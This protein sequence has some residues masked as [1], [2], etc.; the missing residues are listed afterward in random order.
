MGIKTREV[1]GQAFYRSVPVMAGYI[2]LGIGF[3]ILLR[4]AGFGVIWA[5]A[6][7]ALIYA[8]S[9]QYV[10][11]GLLT[12]GASVVTTIITTIMVNARHLFYSISMIDKYKG[13]GKFKPYMIFALTDETYSLLC[14]DRGP[15]AETLNLYRFFVSLFNQCYWVTG[16]VLGSLLGSILPF[17]T[18]GIEFS[19]TALFIASFTEQWIS[20]KE[21]VP[22]LTGLASTVLCLLVFGPQKFLIPSMLLI[23][24]VLSIIRKREVAKA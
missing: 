19:M 16:S 13:A 24:F 12:G 6:M 1:I 17:S 9:M 20:S 22:A 21:H 15:S 3:G 5:F 8:G 18:E 4:N 2:V 7:S 10:G 23:T 14:E 11:I